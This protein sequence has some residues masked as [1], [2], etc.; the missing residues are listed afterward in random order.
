MRILKMRIL[1]NY[2]LE[3]SG[4]EPKKGDTMSCNV[5]KR[6]VHL[7]NNG[8]GPLVC[9][10]KAMVKSKVPVTES[11]FTKKVNWRKIKFDCKNFKSPND[12][13]IKAQKSSYG[14]L[15]Y[16]DMATDLD[17]FL[18][19]NKN[20]EVELALPLTTRDMNIPI[21]TD[22]K[23][24]K[25]KE[26]LFTEKTIQNTIEFL[27]K[28]C[29]RAVSEAGFEDKPEGWTD[30]S[31]KKYA[32]T[33]TKKMKGDVKSKDFFDKCVKKMQGKVDNPEGFCAALKDERHGSTFW[34]G[35]GKTPKE[36]KKDVARHKN[37]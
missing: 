29:R 8:K 12:L 3:I 2:L 5:C 19:I 35:K 31:I 22:I 6:K 37:V 32:K 14:K 26:Y 17:M 21:L 16:E 28:N 4:Y 15:P 1:N 36:V 7:L 25:P 30:Q 10:E 23:Y 20:Y 18:F 24:R 33:F 13:I 27:K 11:W 34:R 9:C